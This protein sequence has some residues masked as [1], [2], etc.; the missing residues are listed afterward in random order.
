MQR[1]QSLWRDNELKKQLRGS[2]RRQ[3]EV[4]ELR[5]QAWGRGVPKAPR[6]PGVAEYRAH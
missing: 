2:R 1:Q 3:D 6:V 4:F 5:V